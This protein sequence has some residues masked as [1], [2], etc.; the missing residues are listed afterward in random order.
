MNFS[1]PIFIF[2]FLPIAWVGWFVAGR[3]S[4]GTAPSIVWIVL[5]SLLFYGWLN[6]D[7]LFV[8]LA[9]VASN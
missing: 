2:L 5:V 9:S 1:D 4:R 7:H 3:L 6:L 8:M